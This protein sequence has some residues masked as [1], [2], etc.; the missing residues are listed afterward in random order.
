M[1]RRAEANANDRQLA[2]QACDM[3]CV[4]LGQKNAT[5]PSNK[6]KPTAAEQVL[7]YLHTK[8]TN[9]HA[10]KQEELTLAAN[11]H[12]EEKKQQEER[13]AL[14]REH[15]DMESRA[16]FERLELEKQRLRAQERDQEHRRVMERENRQAMQQKE[17]GMAEESK[18][19]M[20]VMKA[21]ANKL[22]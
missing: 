5:E 15:L 2:V 14:E 18:A 12:R 1:Q 6:R 13:L 10:L 8:Y 11:K 22:A 7:E 21:L 16:S 3:A 17:Q 9:D 4:A 19:F 20:D